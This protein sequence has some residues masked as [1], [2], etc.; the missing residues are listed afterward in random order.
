MA[1]A[2]GKP[3][4][5]PSPPKAA[6]LAAVAPPDDVAQP[7][8][9]RN[10]W[11]IPALVLAS[12]LLIGGVV[13]AV[14][15]RP[16]PPASIPL[17]EA[18][19]LVQEHRYAEAITRLNAKDVRSFLD[20]GQPTTEHWQAF[21]LARARAFA[22]QQTTL[23]ISR[24]ENNTV[25]LEDFAEAEKRGAEL[26]PSDSSVVVQALI[27][28]GEVEKAQDRIDRLPDAEQARKTRL[29]RAVIEHNLQAKDKRPQMTLQLLA[30]MTGDPAL[31]PEERAWVLARQAEMLIAAGQAEE[32]VGKLI[33]RIG[34][35]K[36]VPPATQAEL[37]VLLGKAYFQNQQ[38]L[39]A[40][41]QF[42]VADSMIDDASPLRG[43]VNV[44][45]G[46]LM[47]SG[48]GG[49]AAGKDPLRVLELA[50]DRFSSVIENFAQGQ[51][52][53][54]ATLGTAEVEAALRHDQP[55]LEQYA[56]LIDMLKTSTRGLGDVTPDVVQ[57]S[58]L[59]RFNERS[60]AGERESALRFALLAETL[61]PD[62]QMPAEILLAIGQT[63]R[64]MGDQLLDQFYKLDPRATNVGAI[65]DQLDASTRA[66]VKQHYVAAG[67]YLRRH[68]RA[69]AATDPAVSMN[70][71]WL[72]ADSFDR[73]GDLDEAHKTFASYAETASDADTN[74]PAAKFRLAQVFQAKREFTAAAAL[75]RQLVDARSVTD[76]ASSAGQ[77]SDAAIVPLAQCLIA[78]SDG[79]VNEQAEQLLISVVDGSRMNPE[80]PAF[81]DALIELGS[82]YY[83]RGRYADAIAWL[84][85]AAKRYKDDAR[86]GS[87]RFRLAD[88]HRME[89][90]SI[91]RT[92][93]SQRLPQSQRAQL[94]QDSQEHLRDARVLYEDVMR[95]LLARPVKSLDNLERIYLRNAHFYVAD[96]AMEMKDYDAAIAAYDAARL[97]YADDP[98][99]MVA[100][101]Q[102]VSAY[103]AQERWAQARTA[104]ERARQQ[105]ARFPESA[106]QNPDLPMEKR[107]WEQWLDAR[108]ILERQRAAAESG[109]N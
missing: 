98:A 103:V 22:G 63:K 31:N 52:L 37:Y 106:W 100:M 73:A 32:A 26:S 5:A 28:A 20:F 58:L 21:H 96:C 86:I 104:N 24:P 34:L 47:Q 42:E 54:R 59:S 38:P 30:R 85:Q 40:L 68:A 6:K 7:V 108:T 15:S 89:A 105:L 87:V 4:Q 49:D 1:D 13:V 74:K 39:E 95:T 16:K 8:R 65:V 50:K 53:A 102:I 62:E 94:E 9:L 72:A 44:M 67:E 12:G 18:K 70:S 71:L 97:K 19:A 33:R 3:E 41:R 99:S 80:A 76:P 83:S 77:W 45:L 109:T 101:A 23:G 55:A 10:I 90:L 36:D 91:R 81:R 2:K 43:E 84:E 51:L 93:A 57:A 79:G 88:S 61:H 66:E 29:T 25:I 64:A 14:M 78:E 17:E 75:F 35:L 46:R 60:D 11:P 92:L 69:T 27:D 56:K 107:H 48:V 82:M